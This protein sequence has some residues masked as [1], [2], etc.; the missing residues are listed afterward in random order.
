MFRFSP[1]KRPLLWLDAAAAIAARRG[2]A[3]FALYGAGP[4]RSD[5]SRRIAALGLQERVILPGLSG[6]PLAALGAMDVFLLTSEA[7]GTPNTVIEAQWA[8]RPVV[9]CRAGGVS[10]AFLPEKTGILVLDP[11][12]GAIAD[13]VARLAGDAAWRARVLAIG[14]SFVSSR[15]ALDKTV[16][17]LI[18]HY[19]FSKPPA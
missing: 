16:S 13:A 1:E 4:M 9:A 8:G 17:A 14:P 10:E 5:I 11:D 12:P 15:F 7:E 6:E 3:M 2:D 18:A 19:G